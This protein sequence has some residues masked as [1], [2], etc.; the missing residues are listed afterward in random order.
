MF[1]HFGREVAHAGKCA[2]QVVLSNVEQT[3]LGGVQQVKH[4]HR[5][6]VCIADGECA[7]ADEFALDAF[8]GD[9]AGV[10]L[11]IGCRGHA[12]AQFYEVISTAHLVQF[13]VFAQFFRYGQNID[14]I[15]AL[16]Q[17]DDGPEDMLVR[18]EVKRVGLQYV[19]HHGQRIA[20]EQHGTQYGFLQRECLGL[21]FAKNEIR[22]AVV[23]LDRLGTFVRLAAAFGVCI[24]IGIHN[25]YFMLL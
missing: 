1:E 15:G 21:K 18:F 9:D 25:G 16:K 10:V 14:R 17:A 2:A 24:G 13:A 4:V 7:Y 20:V 5:L 19:H 22:H 6:V 3:L 8:L 12:V 11:N 23:R